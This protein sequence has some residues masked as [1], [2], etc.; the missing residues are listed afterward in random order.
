V[1]HVISFD[2]LAIN[3]LWNDPRADTLRAYLAGRCDGRNPTKKVST[4]PVLGRT[5]AR[6]Q[7][8]TVQ[9]M[10]SCGATAQPYLDNKGN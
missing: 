6:Q 2:H 5:V 1:F 3:C 9:S 4:V 10:P 8:L 7:E